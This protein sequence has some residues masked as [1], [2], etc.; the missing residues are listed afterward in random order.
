MN[1]DYLDLMINQNL[2]T[3]LIP[4]IQSAVNTWAT[5]INQCGQIKLFIEFLVSRGKR[6]F[7][8]CVQLIYCLESF[9][10]NVCSWEFGGNG[11]DMQNHSSLKRMCFTGANKFDSWPKSQSLKLVSSWKETYIGA[12]TCFNKFDIVWSSSLNTTERTV[13][14]RE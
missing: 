13:L 11:L 14:S 2:F 8:A 12:I 7:N 3:N 10:E 4:K 1:G 6:V 5:T 9:N